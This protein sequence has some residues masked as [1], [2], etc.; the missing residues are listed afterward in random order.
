[1]TLH[2]PFPPVTVAV[3]EY[4]AGR[5]VCVGLTTTFPVAAEPPAEVTVTSEGERTCRRSTVPGMTLVIFVLVGDRLTATA[6]GRFLT[7]TTMRREEALW[8][9]L[10]E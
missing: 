5:P 1:M 6:S 8:I 3:H 4:A 10:P 2:V 9:E 7:V